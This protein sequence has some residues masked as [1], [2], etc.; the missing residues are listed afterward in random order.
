[1]IKD[2]PYKPSA[3]FGEPGTCLAQSGLPWDGRLF[4][5]EESSP[6]YTVA[7]NWQAFFGAVAVLAN[8]L[9]PCSLRN[10]LLILQVDG[11]QHFGAVLWRSRLIHNFHQNCGLQ[12]MS[13]SQ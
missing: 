12:N 11:S 4:V 13:L 8:L 10:A 3:L 2:A 7:V 9:I 5:A 1:M 6:G